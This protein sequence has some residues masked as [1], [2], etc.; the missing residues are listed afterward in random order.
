MAEMTVAGA[1]VLVRYRRGVVGETARC[2]HVVPLATGN[3]AGAV[4]AL[5]GAVLPLAEMDTVA[6]GEGMPCMACVLDRMSG[7]EEEPS[8]GGPDD[9]RENAWP[10]TLHRGQVRL[11]LG[12][13]VSA[14]AIPAPLGAPVIRI[15][16]QR[17]C[18][19]AVLSH[20]YAPDHRIVLTG[21]RY[22]V[23][24]PWPAGTHRVT[25]VMLLPPT[26]T[27]RGPI[28]WAYPPKPDSLRRCR[29]IDL[30]AA[31]R[32]ALADSPDL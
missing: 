16:S 30:F 25:G 21:E 1:V 15:L 23:A 5:C 12:G 31:V 13:D 6:A 17:R 28:T 8:A 29:E 9:L 11:R 4:R 26:R 18:A 7:A 20:P 14:H 3:R 32:T 24:L 22:G 19:P 10:V 27:P 2:V